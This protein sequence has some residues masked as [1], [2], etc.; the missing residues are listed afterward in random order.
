MYKSEIVEGGN[1]D[2]STAAVKEDIGA[3]DDVPEN[4]MNHKMN[5][6]FFCPFLYLR[7]TRKRTDS[8]F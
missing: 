2:A 1:D 4:H 6:P 7:E 5:C 8:T 3:V